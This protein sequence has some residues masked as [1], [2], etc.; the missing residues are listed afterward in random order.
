L[1]IRER[2]A[3]SPLD[4][5]DTVTFLVNKNI[6]DRIM[7]ATLWDFPCSNDPDSLKDD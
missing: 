5:R 3:A 4:G 7:V 6:Q 1:L 2:Y